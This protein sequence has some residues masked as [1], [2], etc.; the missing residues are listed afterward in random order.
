MNGK[1]TMDKSLIDIPT[2]FETARLYLRCFQPGDG[3]MYYAVSQRNRG[4]LSRFESDNVVM[5]IQSLEDA[6]SIVRDLAAEWEA[7]NSFFLGAFDKDSDEFVAQIYVGPANWDLPEFQIGYFV[8]K[9]HEGCGYA[10]EA[11]KATLRFI[12]QHLKAH[13]VRLECDDTNVRSYRVAERCGMVREGHFRET[14]KDSEGIYSGTLYYSILRREFETNNRLIRYQG[15][16]VR[17]HQILLIR[18]L[19]HAEGRSYWLIPGGGIEAGESEEACVQREMREE[20]HLDVRVIR[21]LLDEPGIPGGV[22]QRLKTYL[23]EI[24]RGEAS[25]GYEP[26]VEVGYSIEEVGWF[27]LRDAMTW[28]DQVVEDP[29]TYPLLQRIRTALDYSD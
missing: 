15:V 18:L 13:R 17:D 5:E 10:T 2:R 16:I 14:K 3:Q 7:R 23:C 8:D 27:D 21:L 6:K 9:E 11:V 12:F 26:E 25:P 19:E 28:G 29:I 4:H 24:L 20:T 22:Y 1:I